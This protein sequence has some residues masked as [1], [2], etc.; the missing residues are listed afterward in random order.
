ME[1]GIS[2][3]YGSEDETLALFGYGVDSFVEVIS[4]LGIARMVW[5]MRRNSVD[6][7]DRFEAVALKITGT[8]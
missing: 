6:K 4:G 5:R 7:R 8:A 2:T 1:G 3:F